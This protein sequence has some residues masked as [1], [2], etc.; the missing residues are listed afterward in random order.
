MKRVREC[1]SC[2]NR[3]T[4]VE[5]DEWWFMQILDNYNEKQGRIQ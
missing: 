5:I 4:T 2:G 3:W 1:H